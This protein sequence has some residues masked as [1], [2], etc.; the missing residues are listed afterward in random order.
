MRSIGQNVGNKVIPVDPYS[1]TMKVKVYGKYYVRGAI[2][3]AISC[4]SGVVWPY[5][6]V[7]ALVKSY[8]T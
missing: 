3:V 5:V 4:G 8:C 2:V 1:Y 7:C 6:T